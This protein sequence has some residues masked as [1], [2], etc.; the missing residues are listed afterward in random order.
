M[1][2]TSRRISIGE[3]PDFVMRRGEMELN[4]QAVLKVYLFDSGIPSL[5]DS[6]A[7]FDRSLAVVIE[8]LKQSMESYGWN[9]GSYVPGSDNNPTLKVF[10]TGIYM[11]TVIYKLESNLTPNQRNGLTIEFNRQFERSFIKCAPNKSLKPN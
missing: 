7:P 11:L 10:F 9:S 4:H 2:Q 1:S 6:K 5:K 3:S 8:D